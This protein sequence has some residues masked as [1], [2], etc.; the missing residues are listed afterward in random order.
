VSVSV[1][2]TS[3]TFVHIYKLFIGTPLRPPR[4]MGLPFVYGWAGVSEIPALFQSWD[5]YLV[6]PDRQHRTQTRWP[7]RTLRSLRTNKLMIIR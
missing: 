3:F 4:F 6:G 5:K 7:L 1:F 2:W